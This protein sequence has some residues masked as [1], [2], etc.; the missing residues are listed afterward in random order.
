MCTVWE[1][2]QNGLS[3]PASC[4]CVSGRPRLHSAHGRSRSATRAATRSAEDMGLEPSRSHFMQFSIRPSGASGR[5]EKMR[6]S[7]TAMRVWTLGRI[8]SRNPERKARQ[9]SLNLVGDSSVYRSAC[10]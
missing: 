2:M 6:T 5:I 8:G 7:P 10:C 1:M 9:K 4:F 3:S